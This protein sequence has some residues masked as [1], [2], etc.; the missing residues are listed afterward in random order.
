MRFRVYGPVGVMVSV[1]IAGVLWAGCGGG[2][3]TSTTQI[4]TETEAGGGA[5]GK[6]LEIRMGEFYFEPKSAAATAGQATIEA[7]NDGS[8]EH[9]LVLFKTNKNPANLPTE[10]NG[11]VDEEKLDKEAEGAGEIAD[12]GAGETKS[13]EFDLTPGKYVMF[14][15][16]PGHYAQGMYGTITVTK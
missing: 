7:P 1:A 11:D 10:A 14:C 3:T 16:L 5:G 13:E 8:V 15:N 4:A 6:T 2:D 12:V 9:E